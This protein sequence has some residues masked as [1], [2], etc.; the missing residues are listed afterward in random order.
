[1]GLQHRIREARGA[2]GI[3]QEELAR[4]TGVT[5]NTINRLE[6]GVATD[7]HYST[8]LNLAKALEVSPHWLYSGEEE[9]TPAAPLAEAR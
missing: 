3:S 4:R 9:E 5:L 1:M 2:L 7:P 6:R 8:L